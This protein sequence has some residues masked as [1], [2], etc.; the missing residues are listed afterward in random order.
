MK[1]IEHQFHIIE[2]N[3]VQRQLPIANA[4]NIIDYDEQYLTTP[5]ATRFSRAVRLGKTWR[6]YRV[7]FSTLD[8]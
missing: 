5:V 3:F 8:H 4:R 6:P 2:T 7:V 1:F